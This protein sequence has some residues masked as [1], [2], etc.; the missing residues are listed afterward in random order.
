MG[1]YEKEGGICSNGVC[2]DR[3][4][5]CMFGLLERGQTQVWEGTL[6]EGRRDAGI[7]TP[8]DQAAAFV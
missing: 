1:N 3:L 5:N 8:P 2:M 4:V 7:N 6:P